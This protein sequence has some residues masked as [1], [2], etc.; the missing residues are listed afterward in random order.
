MPASA[1][2][3]FVRPEIT[4]ST[5]QALLTELP[6]PGRASLP[7]SGERRRLDLSMLAGIA[8]ALSATVAGIASTGVSLTYFLQPTG[9]LIVLG[10]TLGVVFI[11]TP[12]TA[13]VRSVRRVIDLFRPLSSVNREDLIEEIVYYARIARTKGPIVMAL[14]TNTLASSCTTAS[15]GLVWTNHL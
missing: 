13:L 1:L 9:A 5:S 8:I 7:D 2:P 12:W 14:A 10:G 15:E 4:V 11:T 3:S 6:G